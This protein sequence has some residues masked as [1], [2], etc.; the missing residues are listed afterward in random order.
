ML[1][2]AASVLGSLAC[3]LPDFTPHR[4]GLVAACDGV[5]EGGRWPHAIVVVKLRVGPRDSRRRNL[6]AG[7][8]AKRESDG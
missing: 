5:T 7:H 1:N 6:A 4:Y 3:S 2:S 8:D